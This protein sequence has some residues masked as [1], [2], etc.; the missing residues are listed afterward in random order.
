MTGPAA[1][2]QGFDTGSNASGYI[3]TGVD[4]FSGGVKS[5]PVQVCETDSAGL[6]TSS[7][8]DLTAPSTFTVGTMSFTVPPNTVLSTATTYAVVV[9][10]DGT[11]LIWDVTFTGDDDT[12]A[13]DGWSIANRAY[14]PN[15]PRF[16]GGYLDDRHH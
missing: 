6:H 15:V 13:A 8:T 1:H 16:P 11:P 9:T 7:C 2:S 3:L 14:I 5:F 4:V 10:D 12:G